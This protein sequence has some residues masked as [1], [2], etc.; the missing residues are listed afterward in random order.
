MK[1]SSLSLIGATCLAVGFA[2][3]FATEH[4]SSGAPAAV[5]CP[6][7]AAA[8][9]REASLPRVTEAAEST[10]LSLLRLAAA[11]PGNVEDPS[12]WQSLWSRLTE[13][14]GDDGVRDAFEK[15]VA[16]AKS[17]PKTLDELMRLLEQSSDPDTKAMVKSLLSQVGGPKVQ[18]YSMR[19]ATSNDPTERREGF[20]LLHRQPSQTAE[21]RQLL[22]RALGKETDPMALFHAVSALQPAA[23]TPS[24]TKE[25]VGLIRGLTQHADPAVRRQSIISL[26]RWDGSGEFVA[27]LRQALSD[28]AQEVRQAAVWAAAEAGNRSGEVKSALLTVLNNGQESP[29]VRKSALHALERFQLSSEEYAAYSQV[30]S[31]LTDPPLGTDEPAGRKTN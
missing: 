12:S 28:D 27:P 9:K 15:L 10:A 30:Q 23:V 16:L 21:V 5:R 18:E 19:L 14:P 13:H 3:G 20:D 2:A 17:D 7:I 6:E 24:E 26:A 29:E 25:V 11:Q 22:K 1:L 4:P 31:N 8:P